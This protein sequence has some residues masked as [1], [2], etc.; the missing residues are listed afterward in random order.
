MAFL[1]RGVSY[2]TI[3]EAEAAMTTYEQS[4]D[5]KAADIAA[6]SNGKPQAASE[7]IEMK[8]EGHTLTIVVDMSKRLGTSAS[9]KSEIVATTRG[10]KTVNVGGKD[11]KLGVNIYSNK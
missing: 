11:Y 4:L 3:G 5:T 2:K 10:N 9:G 1:F 6:K 7:N 8:V